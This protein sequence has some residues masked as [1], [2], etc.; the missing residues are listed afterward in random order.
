MIFNITF[1][2]QASTKD[3][4]KIPKED[5]R[6]IRVDIEN[7]LGSDPHSYS[8]PLKGKLAGLRKFRVGNYRVVLS[9][10][11]QEVL[12]VRILSRDDDTYKKL[13]RWLF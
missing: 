7:L 2:E 5:V 10:N 11:R 1:T 4:K 9:I 12:I 8:K 13:E 6:A 3:T